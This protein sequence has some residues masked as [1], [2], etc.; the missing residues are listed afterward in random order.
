MREIRM[1]RDWD[2][3]PA[4]WEFPSGATETLVP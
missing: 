2:T 3:A 1:V 4:N